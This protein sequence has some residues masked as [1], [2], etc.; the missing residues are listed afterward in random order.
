MYIHTR[1]SL[2]SSPLLSGSFA[3]IEARQGPHHVFQKDDAQWKYLCEKFQIDGIPSYVLVDR[4]GSYKL[5]NDFRDR[6]LMK[7]TLKG[8]LE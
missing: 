6:D 3:L 1:S 2:F 7:K 8:M 4:D 5:R